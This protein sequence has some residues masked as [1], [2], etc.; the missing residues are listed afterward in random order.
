MSKRDQTALVVVV[1]VVLLVLGW[2]NYVI[3]HRLQEQ[4]NGLQSQVSNLRSS[5]SS[6]IHSVVATVHAIKEEA[7]W[8]HPAGTAIEERGPDKA[9]VRVSWQVKDLQEGAEVAFNYRRKDSPGFTEVPVEEEAK[10]YY[11]AVV[12]VD[13]A[14]EPQWHLSVNRSSDSTR[15]IEEA[16]EFGYYRNELTYEY[17]FT[18]T[19]KGTVRSGEIQNLYVGDLTAQL[20]NPLSTFVDI[21]RQGEIRVHFFE[22]MYYKDVYY[23]IQEVALEVRQGGRLIERTPFN[24][25]PQRD[26]PV[27]GIKDPLEAGQRLF[28]VVRYNHNKTIEREILL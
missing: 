23:Q 9:L 11:S 2:Q 15:D 25:V 22:D 1:A 5:I 18:L 21:T 20:F 14:G 6:D 16:V 28:I 10:G 12:P 27:I 24:E 19:H 3:S 7:R 4:V 17:F 8:W 26:M 13:V